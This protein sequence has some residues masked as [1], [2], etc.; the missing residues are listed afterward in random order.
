MSLETTGKLIAETMIFDSPV[1][2]LQYSPENRYLAVFYKCCRIVIFSVEKGYQPVKN[3]DYEFPN[4]NYFSLAFSPDDKL[5]ANISSN[6]NNITVWETKNFSLKY[7]LDLTGD[8]IQKVQFA[9][10]GRDIVALT[11]SSK[12]KFYRISSSFASE[13]QFSKD[14]YGVTDLECTDFAISPNC[15]YIAVSG[16][17]GVVKIFDYFMRGAAVPSCQAFLGHFKHPR[18]L[19]WS[20]DMRFIFSVGDGNGIFRWSFFGDREAPADM[21]K[22]YEEIEAPAPLL[23]VESGEPTFNHDTLLRQANSQVDD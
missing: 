19:Y 3:I 4:E 15:K 16:R 21:S 22:H 7:H 9:P 8:I 20:T 1:T 23:K 11:S 14:I 6:A 17:E 12:L 13:L 2:D 18:K 5:L 10:N